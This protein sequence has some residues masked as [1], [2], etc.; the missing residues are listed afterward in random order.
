VVTL[1]RYKISKPNQYLLSFLLVTVVSAF[2][3]SLP[4]FIP[5]RVVALILLLT[6][7]LIA[8]F[9]DIAPVMVAA[10]S[11]AL[12]WDYFF[13]PPRFT[14][15]VYSAED[16][17]MLLM[18][19]VIALLNA[20]LTFKIRQVEKRALREEGKAN[21]IKLYNTLLNSLSHELRTPIATIVGASDNLL[22]APQKLTEQNKQELVNEISKASFRMNQQ[23]EN[24]LNMSRLESGFIQ[25][26]RIWC[27][28]NELIYEAVNKL[29][30]ELKNHKVVVSV[31]E[32][33]PLFKI[34]FGLMEHA[35]FNLINNAATYTPDHSVITITAS[36]TEEFSTGKA[37]L[38][39]VVN[40][41]I[42]TVTD[43]GKGFLADEVHRVFE[44]FYRSK[45]SGTG[46]TGL[47]LSIVKGFVEAHDGKIR[48]ENLSSGGAKF[49][50]E[51]P[52]EISYLNNLKNE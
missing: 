7:S 13:I 10:A 12:I 14:F 3:F 50:I 21:T 33:F 32:K 47:G 27:D 28:V 26:H 5:Y 1:K 2:C 48:L 18:Y 52:A 23:I 42:I 38:E 15:S 45:N 40:E 51:I 9:F 43:N 29:E 8:M 39:T 41:L 30:V 20:V 46:G 16:S 24:L 19:F 44:K 36:H 11:S 37:G 49:I 35:L 25:P 34:D 4:S 17:L 31:P 6:V 22:A